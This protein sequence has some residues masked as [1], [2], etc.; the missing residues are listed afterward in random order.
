MG[1]TLV[2]LM[3]EDLVDDV[4]QGLVEEVAVEE[5]EQEDDES[6]EKETDGDAE[7]DEAE[8]EEIEQVAI[9]EED[10]E[11]EHEVESDDQEDDPIVSEMEEEEGDGA[12]VDLEQIEFRVEA[13]ANL[14]RAFAEQGVSCS[15][16]HSRV[17]ARGIDAFV[18][19][20]V[21]QTGSTL[22]SS[23][24]NGSVTSM[25]AP[26]L[27][28]LHLALA[29]RP[30]GRAAS[31]G[32]EEGAEAVGTSEEA[33]EVNTELEVVGAA[34]VS[35]VVGDIRR[36]P[37]L[38]AACLILFGV[39]PR[40]RNQGIGTRLFDCIKGWAVRE[41]QVGEGMP[42][43][44]QSLLILSAQPGLGPKWNRE[45][46]WKTEPKKARENWWIRRLQEQKAWWRRH[47][48]ED[49]YAE[50][51]DLYSLKNM[52]LDGGRSPRACG[53][54]RLRREQRRRQR[55]SCAHQRLGDGS[56][57]E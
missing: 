53:S 34:V 19:R 15:S 27:H 9:D 5:N 14:P 2:E 47:S 43:T 21:R 54:L 10:E 56:C 18:L 16:P 7:V 23:A 25:Q 38:W 48:K 30:R 40:V 44:Y 24:M 4:E 3:G 17:W 13:V 35:K 26:E 8:A 42:A 37:R 50:C 57:S 45:H 1:E 20:K 52:L 36:D 55:H 41:A 28:G 46:G 51:E 49:A 33:A 39:D 31:N 32:E 6:E 11:D 12:S 22:K 29:L